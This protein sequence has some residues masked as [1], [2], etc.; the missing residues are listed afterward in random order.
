ML[1]RMQSKR[2]T[3]SCWWKSKLVQPLCK[4]VQWFPRKLEINLP[5]IPAILLLVIY[6]KDAQSYYKDICLT[7]FIAALFETTQMPLKQ[8]MVLKKCVTFTHQSSTQW[9]GANSYAYL[10]P[11][12]QRALIDLQ[13]NSEIERKIIVKRIESIHMP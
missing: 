4:L 2:R 6:P 12:L 10:C 7:K 9:Q 5:Q 13:Q 1:E 11:F 3:H 8:R